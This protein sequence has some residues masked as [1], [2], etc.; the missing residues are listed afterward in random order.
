MFK[1]GERVVVL[2][3]EFKDFEGKVLKQLNDTLVLIELDDFISKVVTASENLRK[4]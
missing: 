1:K 4:I 2:R 3:D